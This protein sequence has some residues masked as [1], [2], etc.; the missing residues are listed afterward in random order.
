MSATL[1]KEKILYTYIT[2]LTT[3]NYIPGVIA[4]KKSLI[5]VG[6]KYP[7]K[8]FVKKDLAKQ[9]YRVGFE[10]KEL[11]LYDNHLIANNKKIICN[12][13]DEHMHWNNTFDKLLIF[14]LVEYEKIVFLDADMMICSNIDE[15]FERPH[16]SAVYPQFGSSDYKR[17]FNSGL[18]VIEPRQ[19]LDKLIISQLEDYELYSSL[20][21]VSDN[22]LLISYYSNW[23]NNKDLLLDDVYNVFFPYYKKYLKV[24]LTRE[25]LKVIHFIG[26]EKV[27]MHNKLEIKKLLQETKLACNGSYELLCQYLQLCEVK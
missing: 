21:G 22:D 13:V 23:K 5:S 11:I 26:K 20:N 16:M 24:G 4:L 12:Q 7:L 3:G 19:S 9:L 10:E 1:K 25:E 8:I 27:W 14:S 2:T 17:G 18:M 6:S 15:L